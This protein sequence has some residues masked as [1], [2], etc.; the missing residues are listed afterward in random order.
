MKELGFVANEGVVGLV[1]EFGG[2]YGFE[3]ARCWFGHG[4]STLSLYLMDVGAFGRNG[5]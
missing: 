1:D 2:T 4:A 5:L 3:R